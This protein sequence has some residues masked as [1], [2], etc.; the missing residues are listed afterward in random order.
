YG[1]DDVVR[2]YQGSTVLPQ[3]PGR[4]KILVTADTDWRDHLDVIVG[5][6]ADQGGVACINATAVFVE[7]DPAPVAEALAERLAGIPVLPPTDPGAV[8]PVQDVEGARAIES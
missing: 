1:G 3:G 2:K 7:G 8:L 6:V 5:S 4:S